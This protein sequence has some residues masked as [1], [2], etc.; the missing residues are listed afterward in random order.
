MENQKSLNPQAVCNKNAWC[1]IIKKSGQNI[2]LPFKPTIITEVKAPDNTKTASLNKKIS[3]LTWQMHQSLTKEQRERWLKGAFY[4]MVGYWPNLKNPKTFNEKIC[5]YRLYYE[6]PDIRKI[7]DKVEF[8]KYINDVLGD[9]YTPKLFGV[10]EDEWEIDLDTLPDQFV[11]KSTISAEANNIIF[12]EDKKSLDQEQLRYAVS[13]WLQPWNTSSNSFCNWYRD[14]QPRALAEELLQ[15]AD[16]GDLKDYKI[17][18]FGGVPEFVLVLAERNTGKYLNFYDLNWTL[19]PFERKFNNA[20]Y[21][22]DK[23]GQFDKMVEIAKILSKPFPF[24]RVDFYEANGRV[25]VGE[26][27]FSPGGG[28]HPFSPKNGTEYWEKK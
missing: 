7:I 28:L 12:V 24:V 19:L 10:Y 4:N 13:E 1:L 21:P 18:C 9:G 17:N 27:T 26:L 25:Y 20:P 15:P 16:G 22:I 14:I 23:P 5:W 8:K 11:L 6:H 3:W 2:F